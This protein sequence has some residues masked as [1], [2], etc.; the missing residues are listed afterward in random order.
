MKAYIVQG[1]AAEYVGSVS[2]G[3]WSVGSAGSE[4]NI[5]RILHLT[6]WV[7]AVSLDSKI[8]S[9]KCLFLK[10]LGFRAL[11]VN[12]EWTLK[13]LNPPFWAAERP[14]M[15]GWKTKGEGRKDRLFETWMFMNC[16]R[17]LFETL[18]SM[19]WFIKKPLICLG[20]RN[21]RIVQKLMRDLRN[22]FPYTLFPQKDFLHRFLFEKYKT[23]R[24]G[25]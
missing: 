1:F 18:M 24:K 25:E 5:G 21:T 9:Q 2:G 20:T 12:T 7:L 14:K 3:V 8:W 23:W 13:K 11:A 15:K 16:S 4:K 22:N 10:S 19:N 17:S 6:F